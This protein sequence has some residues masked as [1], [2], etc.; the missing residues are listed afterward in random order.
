MC[1]FQLS[2]KPFPCIFLADL[3]F[4]SEKNK[5]KISKRA[6]WTQQSRTKE[7]QSKKDTVECFSTKLK[8]T[9]KNS[10]TFE[11]KKFYPQK[12]L[13][14]ALAPSHS[15]N[16]FFNFNSSYRNE[17]RKCLEALY[18]TYLGLFW[19]QCITTIVWVISIAT[20]KHEEGPTLTTKVSVNEVWHTRHSTL[21]VHDFMQVYIII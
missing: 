11:G 5:D 16:I 1:A 13:M 6:Q 8:S 15:I 20:K 4:V 17:K 21:T 14:R 12:S 2:S 7:F 18:W 10:G 9:C 19:I 3:H